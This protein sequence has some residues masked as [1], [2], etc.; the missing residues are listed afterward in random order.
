MRYASARQIHNWRTSRRWRKQIAHQLRIQ[1]LC[2]FCLRKNPP[3]IVPANVVDHIDRHFGD[4]A[5]FFT[6]PTQNLCFGCH[7]VVK[8]QM[9]R[10]RGFDR[11]IGRDGFPVSPDHPFNR[12]KLWEDK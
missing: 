2:V 12:V 9:E 8:R 1:P 5:A 11:T 4:K 7:D 3:E 10:G 6:G